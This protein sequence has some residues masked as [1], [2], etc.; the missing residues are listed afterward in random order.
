MS[1]TSLTQASFWIGMVLAL[2]GCGSRELKVA[3]PPTYSSIQ[4][5]VIG[6]K[7]LQ[8]HTSL[9]TYSGVMRIVDPGNPG[10]SPFYESIQ[11]GEMPQRSPKL[12]SV[13]LQAVRTWISNG[14]QND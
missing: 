11:S 12:S 13:E 4:K 14:A 5:I 9:A 8:C 2:P 3:V 10:S 7:C 6:P 1:T